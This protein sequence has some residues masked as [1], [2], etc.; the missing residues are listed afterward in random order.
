MGF[1]KS[2]RDWNVR[3]SQ[4]TTPDS[5]WQKRGFAK[6]DLIA[7]AE[8]GRPDVQNVADVGGG[9]TWPFAET[10][11]GKPG[12]HLT[13]VDISAD[14]LE[15]N[16]L[17]HRAV[18]ADICKTMGVE[19]GTLDLILSR[20]TVERLHDTSG[21]LRGAYAALRPGGRIV[22]MFASKWAISTL[23][24]RMMTEGM[25]KRILYAL[26]PNSKGYQGFKA[27]YDK[28]GHGEFR[29]AAKAVGFRIETD[30]GSYY[31]SSYF[32]FFWP[33]HC[34]S[35]AH[36]MLRMMISW[37]ALNSINLFVLEKPTA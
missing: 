1:L 27:F 6:Y 22:L 3:L 35:I 23:L 28:C 24:N 14:E 25:A 30:Y 37:K 13:G 18:T 33:L 29:D 8:L 31:A 16:P 20:A 10:Y 19:D 11:H 4:A 26:V 7:R 12:F 34:V 5:L 36:D 2:F 21:F 15:L 9:R 32:Q 17:L